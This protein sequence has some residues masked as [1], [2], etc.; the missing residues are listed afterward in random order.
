MLYYLDRFTYLRNFYEET[1]LLAND[2][3]AQYLPNY[4]LRFDD[5]LDWFS[6]FPKLVISYLEIFRVSNTKILSA[7]IYPYLQN[8]GSVKTFFDANV[9]YV[10]NL[11]ERKC[12]LLLVLCKSF[13]AYPCSCCYAFH[14]YYYFG[15]SQCHEQFSPDK[16][17]LKGIALP[18]RPCCLLE[19]F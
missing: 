13:W 10:V 15:N 16:M 18:N 6:S 19:R 11:L 9:F 12:H 2:D 3:R 1:L 17:D 8:W 4:K 5:L 7:F 14:C